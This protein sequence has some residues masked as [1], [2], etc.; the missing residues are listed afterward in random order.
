[1]RAATALLVPVLLAFVA[2]G[3]GAEG[4]ERD[5]PGWGKFVDPVGET[6][7]TPDGERLTLTVPAGLF[8]LS[9]PG[10]NADRRMAAPRVLREVT[11]DFT[12]TVRVAAD[13][14]PGA[15]LPPPSSLAYNG[16]G[17]LV[18]GSEDDFVRLERNVYV[19]GAEA[20]NMTPQ[21]F[22]RGRRVNPESTTEGQFFPARATWIRIRRK[23]QALGTY[24]SADGKKWVTTSRLQ[25]TLPATVRVGALAVNSSDAPFVVTF[26]AFRVE[27]K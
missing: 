14:R 4:D 11:G 12:V 10:A 5:I 23:G 25:T 27:R 9:P 26:D 1:M 16:A 7:A 24:L 18:W 20:C 15:R 6:K 22:Q 19:G 17:L 8:D 13:W 21:Y 2:P 3:R